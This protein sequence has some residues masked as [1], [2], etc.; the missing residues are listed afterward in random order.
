[1]K[2]LTV[3]AKDTT[4]P[5]L[6]A[7]RKSNW[8]AASD[9]GPLAWCAVCAQA[10]N[11][12][13][14]SVLGQPA[15]LPL[16]EGPL[17]ESLQRSF[18]VRHTVR[19][20]RAGKRFNVWVPAFTDRMSPAS[21]YTGANSYFSTDGKVLRK[22]LEA[23]VPGITDPTM[24]I[25][26]ALPPLDFGPT[27]IHLGFQSDEDFVSFKN[28]VK[29]WR[30]TS[31]PCERAFNDAVG[32]PVRE[33]YEQ[34]IADSYG[35]R[36]YVGGVMQNRVF[37]LFMEIELDA[38]SAEYICQGEPQLHLLGEYFVRA[39]ESSYLLGGAPWINHVVPI[40]KI[41]EANKLNKVPAVSRTDE[42]GL[43]V[44]ERGDV[45]WLPTVENTEFIES[46]MEEGCMQP[47][48]D[49]A[50]LDTVDPEHNEYTTVA[51]AGGRNTRVRRSK[52]RNQLV[53]TDWHNA[54]LSYTDE[55]GI[56][57]LMDLGMY[58]KATV[59]QLSSMLN[60]RLNDESK[61]ADVS[62]LGFAVAR[63]A[64][65]GVRVDPNP[66][67]YAPYFTEAEAAGLT[68]MINQ[69]KL[70]LW[71][72]EVGGRLNR[73][74]RTGMGARQLR[75]EEIVALDP[76]INDWL[77]VDLISEN[78]P[79][80]PLIQ[81]AEMLRKC[82]D[83]FVENQDKIFGSH[84]VTTMLRTMAVLLV[85]VKYAG[86]G[87]QFNSMDLEAR[88]KYLEPDLL[89]ADQIE[90]ENVPFVSGK[91]ELFPHQVK[92][93]NF[94]KNSPPNAV[95]DV[96]AGGGKTM[97]ALL[98][99][100]Y[101]L[102]KGERLPLVIC[103]QNLLKNYIQDAAYLFAGRMNMVVL[104]GTTF[105]SPEWGE[106]KL[107]ALVQHA[108]PNTIFLTD[109]NFLIPR[110][111]SKRMQT[112][113]Y[114][115]EAI[116]IS[117]NT[118]FLRSIPWTGIWMDE[119]HLT[120]N[121]SGSTNQELMR[122]TAN[123]PV[124]RQLS[125][126]YISDNLT[127]VVGQ[128]AI[129]SPT[130]FGSHQEFLDTYYDGKA[131]KSGVQRKI[132]SA[133]QEQA[134]VITIRRK[135]WASLLPRRSD[136]FFAVELSPA[137]R[138]V[139][140]K[141][142]DIQ[143]EALAEA[144][145]GNGP[146]EDA[147]QDADIELDEGVNVGA[148]DGEGVKDDALD[149]MLVFYL[150]RLERFITA[151]GSDP[152][153]IENPSVLSGLDL[154]S[155]KVAKVVEILTQHMA[156]KIPGKCMVWTQYVES[157]ASI[158]RNLPNNIRS[159][160]VLYTAG[161]G[162]QDILEFATNPKKLFMVGCEKSMNTGHNLQFCSRIIRCET[163]WNYGTLEQGESRIN[164]PALNDPRKHE[165]GGQ[166]IFYDWVFCNLTCDVTKNARMMSKL[167][168][169]IKFYERDNQDYQ[170]L[171][172]LTPIVLNQNNIFEINDWQDE[173]KGCATYFEAYNQY[174][175]L[176]EK[177][178]RDFADDP[179][180]RIEPYTLSEGKILDGA[181]MFKRIPY[182]PQMYLYNADKLG[183]IPYIQHVSNNYAKGSKRP[184]SDDPNWSPAGLS[185]HTEYGDCVV[186]S[187]FK[188]SLRIVTPN[189]DTASV[190]KAMCW[191]ITRTVANGADIRTA[192][193]NQIGADTSKPPVVP[194]EILPEQDEQAPEG[195]ADN[196]E[197]GFDVFA[198]TYNHQLSLVV[199]LADAETNG[200]TKDL[201]KI[202]FIDVP[203]YHYAKVANFRVLN[204]WLKKI[205]VKLN[206]H[207]EYLA[208]LEADAARWKTGKTPEKFAYGLANSGRKKFL[209]TGKKP[210][211]KGTIKPY[212]IV[213]AGH[214]MLCLNDVVNAASWN[215]ARNTTVSGIKWGKV[216]G[217]LWYFSSAKQDAQ[218]MAKMLFDRFN[219][220]NRKEL[221]KEL[222]GIKLV[223]IT[224]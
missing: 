109:Y 114:G 26:V 69:G 10:F 55:S 208:N 185:V 13:Y 42:N 67:L 75:P 223:K 196:D 103:P 129:M 176:E 47:D 3:A 8:M 61:S 86:Q 29:G 58:R 45:L 190:D 56:I 125:G 77:K 120:K 4:D 107:R 2:I 43:S 161:N 91:V 102:G 197:A 167:I 219:V 113:V 74:S 24:A 117:L 118:E 166:G 204:A 218:R 187:Q 205:Q 155:P 217:E 162:A 181:G 151:P 131:P 224:K 51:G 165:N 16:A 85:V 32:T 1:M 5:K 34:G 222:T 6:I 199:N 186:K 132:Y 178:F 210:V 81:L 66:A 126:T 80:T 88:K 175:V 124:K 195:L 216:E 184:F 105:N 122:L 200:A 7:Y 101:H 41:V 201:L 93:W 17:T 192:L 54:R 147:M 211:P 79:L 19:I 141:I 53:Y 207:P 169:T 148:A 89:P 65:L 15:K 172:E 145:R 71:A 128:F 96:A 158:Y 194:A 83:T 143:R 164:R 30:L 52:G 27:G 156:A 189:G 182:I 100:A 142:L 9:I 38:M 159:Q 106:E 108:P 139:Y 212:L 157:A 70:I 170:D 73:I 62:M 23:A 209:L 20:R 40:R 11:V 119:S 44:N 111:G 214:I 198:E 183:L 135:E 173:H 130:T 14:A 87:A 188:H 152:Y 149:A 97:L 64:E 49:W 59:G 154:V 206:I 33:A 127:D 136:E 160:T 63:G 137:Q 21:W 57:E 99:I 146:G 133:M 203:K 68:G 39:L 35:T 18:D 144:T 115:S 104:N 202:G 220:T 123:I 168:S 121:M 179:K 215:V 171:P 78:S 31:A 25:D 92:A 95:L 140:Y 138:R 84:V 193:E 150:A 213:H 37:V 22:R 116:D 48:G 180:N 90:V 163:V 110:K 28:A 46:D 72:N 12:W 76:F 94:F 82:Y 177:E 134:N 98:D 50:R 221:V 36:A 60:Q 112:L 153:V 174:A 191:V